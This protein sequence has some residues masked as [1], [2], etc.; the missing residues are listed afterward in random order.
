MQKM[1]IEKTALER[2]IRNEEEKVREEAIGAQ[3][4]EEERERERRSDL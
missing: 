4:G 2:G 3:E 1:E